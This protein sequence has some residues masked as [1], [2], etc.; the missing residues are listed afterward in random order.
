MNNTPVP[1]SGYVIGVPTE[2][3][4]KVLANSDDEGYG[5]SGVDAGSG[6]VATSVGSHGHEQS[7][8]VDLPPLAVVI[9]SPGE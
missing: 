3:E 8:S 4:W 6:L 1:R 5:G 2:G 7:I 9:L